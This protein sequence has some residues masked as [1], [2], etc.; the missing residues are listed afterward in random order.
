MGRRLLIVMIAAGWATAPAEAAEVATHTKCVLVG[1][2]ECLDVQ[3][4][5]YVAAPGE[6]N[7][8]TITIDGGFV[9]RDRVPIAAGPGCTPRPDGAVV[10]DAYDGRAALGDGDDAAYAGVPRTRF[11]DYPAGFALEGGPGSD[12]LWGGGR[13]HGGAGDDEL[14]G[15]VL[16]GDEGSDRLTGTDLADSLYGGADEDVLAGLAGNDLLNGDGYELE[17]AVPATDAIDGGDGRDW[18]VYR[19][20]RVPVRVDLGAGTGGAEGEA[21]RLTSVESVQGGDG[22]DVLIGDNGRNEL[23]G[24]S[25]T[26]TIEGRGGDDRLESYDRGIIDGGAGDDDLNGG[27]GADR[28]TGGAGD[29]VLEGGWGTDDY[30]AGPGDDLLGLNGSSLTGETIRCGAGRDEISAPSRAL[31]RRDCELADGAR[32]YPRRALGGRLAFKLSHG[33]GRVTLRLFD[34]PRPFAAARFEGDRALLRVPPAIRRLRRSP[35]RVVV[36]VWTDDGIRLRW[37]I[38]LPR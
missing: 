29:D 15:R 27:N 11:G 19:G 13:L 17:T 6:T 30:R 22:D 4:A 5:R 25:G 16:H 1:R 34:R 21:D 7:E 12:V 10:C 24:W 2:D 14:A 9:F 18:L 20:H 31:L 23:H 38:D 28:L 37:V 3:E 26:N 36:R 8:L 32:V 33:P 35:L